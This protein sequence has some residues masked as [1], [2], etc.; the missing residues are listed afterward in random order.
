VIIF[1]YPQP[2]N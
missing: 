1:L 2:K